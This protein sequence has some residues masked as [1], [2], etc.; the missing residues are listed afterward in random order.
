MK[1]PTLSYN[2]KCAKCPERK[3]SGEVGM[4]RRWSQLGSGMIDYHPEDVNLN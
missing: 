4:P 1:R 3:S 2:S